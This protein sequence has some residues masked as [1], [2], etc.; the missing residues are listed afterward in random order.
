M[1]GPTGTR[2]AI[3][4]SGAGRTPLARQRVKLLM[5]VLARLALLFV[6]V[7]VVE[8]M[9]LIQMG[10]WVGLLPTVLLVIFTG[11]TGAWLARAEGLRVLFQ[12]QQETA[13]GRLPAQ[14]LQ[15][16][17]AVLLGGAFLLTPGIL[18]DVVGFS[19]LFP[20]TRK[21]L[22]QRMRRSLKA[23]I[24]SGS[25]NWV[26]MSPGG[27]RSG[28]SGF[29]GEGLREAGRSEPEAVIDPDRADGSVEG[30]PSGGVE[31]GGPGTG[32]DMDGG[33]SGP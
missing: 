27:W 13:A 3:E 18:T 16:G 17:L 30:D 22:Q 15:D 12:F 14:S 19:L 25:V 33:R 20:P 11:V 32:N 7:P 5:N 10:R 4:G 2:G 28:G 1:N 6:I 24:A 23:G 29:G 9:L 31:L 21:W 8:L 26:V